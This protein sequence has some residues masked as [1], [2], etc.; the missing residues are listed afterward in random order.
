MKILA[1]LFAFYVALLPKVHSADFST[2][3]GS[4]YNHEGEVSGQNGWTIDDPTSDLSFFVLL[5]G[6]D[7]AALGGFYA[8]PEGSI[9]TLSH[10]AGIPLAGSTFRVSIAILPSTDLFPGRDAFGWTLTGPAGENLFTLRFVPAPNNAN[11]LNITWSTGTGGFVSTGWAISYSAPYTFDLKFTAAGAVDL[12][13]TAAITGATPFSFTGSLPGLAGKMWTS[14]GAIFAAGGEE[15]GDNY[16]I[17]DNLTIATLPV[18]DVDGDGYSA[19]AEEWFGTS[20]ADRHSSPA[21]VLSFVS[22]NATLT[23]PSV[24]GRSYFVEWSEDLSVWS[25]ASVT[26]AGAST[27][28]TEP[29]PAPNRRFFRVRK[30]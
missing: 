14:A 24:E 18:A 29:S 11:L 6:S 20:D 7:A 3:F 13:F 4:D 12:G 8:V 9:A 19:E 25:S 5:N 28:W 27:S 26:A 22:G 17:F 21:A 2:T 10:P 23:F 16:M 30:P 15:Y 1:V